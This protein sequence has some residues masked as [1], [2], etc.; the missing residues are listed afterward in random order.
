METITTTPL[1]QEIVSAFEGIPEV[2]SVYVLH[3]GD[4]LKVFTIVNDDSEQLSDQIYDR[5]LELGRR[6]SD[7]HFDFNLVARRNRPIHQLLGSYTP[8]WERRSCPQSPSI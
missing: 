7:I 4:V 5:E 8:V 1:D 6:R 2:E 3:R